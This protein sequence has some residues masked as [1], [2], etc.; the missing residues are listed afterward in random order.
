[1]MFFLFLVFI[2][3]SFGSTISSNALI[4]YQYE[5]YQ[6]SW[7]SDGSPAGIF[8]KPEGSSE[9]SASTRAFRLPDNEPEWISGD[10]LA[11]KMYIKYQTWGS[12]L[13][14]YSIVFLP[15]VFLAIYLDD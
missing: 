4:K 7:E 8:Y 9:L 3:I 10:P 12:V 2:L 14:Y 6:E 13:K 11:E 15:L 1:M 5:N